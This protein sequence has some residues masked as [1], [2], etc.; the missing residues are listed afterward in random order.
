M[1]VE[2]VTPL[3]VTS[4]AAGSRPAAAASAASRRSASA[5]A[6][7]RSP[8][9]SQPAPR[10]RHA[11]DC[12]G[13][14]APHVDRH[15]SRL[16]SSGRNYTQRRRSGV[17]R[18]SHLADVGAPQCTDRIDRLVHTPTSTNEVDTA[19]LDLHAHP[20]KTDPKA[21]PPARQPV[22]RGGPLG[23]YE[24]V[25]KREH[26]QAGRQAECLSDAGHVGQRVER[27]GMPQS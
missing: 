13:G 19:G 5:E 6:S 9:E 1:L 18:R 10:T 8:S 16:D 21:E 11:A 4:M 22:H 23:Q 3:R 14:C 15:T 7:P 26:E 24:R 20:P 17:P 2:V 12:C 25:V 27:M